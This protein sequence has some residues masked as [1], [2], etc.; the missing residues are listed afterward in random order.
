MWELL[1]SSCLEFCASWIGCLF[2]SLNSRSFLHL[3]L[4]PSPFPSSPLLCS[5]LLRHLRMCFHLTF[6][7]D[8]FTYPHFPK[9]NFLL[10]LFSLY[11]SITVSSR[12]LICSSVSSNLLIPSSAFLIFFFNRDWLFLILFLK[13]WICHVHSSL[14]SSE[15]LYGHYFEHCSR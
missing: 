11:A 13:L 9:N 14:Q 3:S 4:S 7:K 15:H 8:L 5:H 6:K 1:G 10:L 12:L 2:P